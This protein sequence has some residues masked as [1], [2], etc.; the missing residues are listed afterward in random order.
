M[1]A[2]VVQL[3]QRMQSMA[4]TG[5]TFTTDPYDVA[6]YTELQKIAAELMTLRHP[7]QALPLLNAFKAEAGYATPKVDVRAI[8][9]RE[10]LLLMAREADDG[11]WAPPGGWADVGDRPS[12]AVER[13]VREETGL[14]VRAVQ[15]LGVW[16]RNLHGHTPFPFHAYKLFLLCEEIGGELQTSAETVEVGFFAPDKLPPLSQARVVP[17]QIEICLR[18]AL[19]PD[20]PA[21]FD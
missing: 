3:A 6:R 17:G 12:A 16:D 18:V 7:E 4:Q 13:E 19:S 8:V 21:Y 9:L 1:N 10:G 15:L 14:E 5:L 11:L 2:D 20:A